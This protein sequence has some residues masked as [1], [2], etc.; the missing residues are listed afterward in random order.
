[1]SGY[2]ANSDQVDEEVIRTA[3]SSALE[4]RPWLVG[5]E[6]AGEASE[7]PPGGAQ[8]QERLSQA[9]PGAARG[10]PDPTGN[11]SVYK[12]R[13]ADFTNAEFMYRNQK[14]ISEA[15]A[16]GRKVVIIP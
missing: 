2:K 12:I 5:S 4:S 8:I 1:M 6:G 15:H 3:V 16:R 13:E 10:K 14:A 7:K 11:G 9:G